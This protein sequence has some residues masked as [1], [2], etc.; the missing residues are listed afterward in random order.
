MALRPMIGVFW[1]LLVFLF[2]LL[3]SLVRVGHCFSVRISG[4][5]FIMPI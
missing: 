1:F 2:F 3:S 4:N 5:W